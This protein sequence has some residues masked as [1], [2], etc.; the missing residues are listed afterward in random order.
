[1]DQP[2]QLPSDSQLLVSTRLGLPGTW[3]ELVRRHGEALTA[4][5]G[6]NRRRGSQRDVTRALGAFHSEI[7]GIGTPSEDGSESPP[8]TESDVRAVRPRMISLLT[9][10]T[11]GPGSKVNDAE[12]HAIAEAFAALPEPW[13]TALWHRAVELQPPAQFAPMLGRTATE[14]AA[15]VQRAEAG[16]FEAFLL[17]Q[18]SHDDIDD[19]CRPFIRLLGGA[20]RSS[21]S[22]HEQRVADEHLTPTTSR[23]DGAVACEACTRRVEVSRELL[24]LIPSAIVPALTGLSVDKYRAGVGTRPVIGAGRR[25]KFALAAGVGLLLVVLGAGAVLVRNV[26]E[27]LDASSITNETE[28]A[29][30]ANTELAKGNE[31]KL[32]T[33]TTAPDSTT[34]TEVELRPARTEPENRV[35]VVLPEIAAPV[36]FASNQSVLSIELSSPGPIFAGGTGTIDIVATNNTDVMIETSAL[37]EV[38]NGVFFADL[39]AGDAECVDPDDDWASCTFR[40]PAASS[41]TLTV[42][43]SLASSVVGS[44]VVGSNLAPDELEVPI[45]AVSRLLHSSIDH[46][47]I[48]MVG[49]TLMTCSEL[50]PACLDARD[51]VGDVL[52]RWDLPGAFIG[53]NPRL[54]WENSSAASFDIGNG[55]IEAAYLFW[56]GD[57]KERGVEIPDDGSNA[58][59][60][61][62][63]PGGVAGVKIEA[64]QI[65]RGDVDATQYFGVADVTD[66]IRS[67][68]PG[69]YLVGNVQ[70]VEVQGSYA[71]WSMVIITRDETLPRRSMTVTTPFSWFSP[72][73]VYAANIA[74]PAGTGKLAYLDVLAF[75]GDRSFVP[76]RLTIGGQVLGD[77]VFDSSIAGSRIPAD[78]N[79]FGMDI[80]AYNLKID[81]PEGNL[82]IKATSDEDGVRLA[83]LALAID[84]Q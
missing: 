11:Y 66:I 22:A 73:D 41:T 42:R 24:A 20:L 67:T 46:G 64:N 17:A 75:E 81:A 3:N 16:L 48:I 62:L 10:G 38:P 52:N 33:A 68:G 27:K 1:M 7:S 12:L 9:G 26:P 4:V 76:E 78:D 69:Q 56:S 31:T 5:A 65:R 84:V 30:D 25:S 53:S 55:S 40:I 58:S 18:R 74:V 83:V 6:S 37:L 13:Q 79:N 39:V 71:G 63:G 15:L 28:A 36:G 2:P 82:N 51:G 60:S 14:S 57:L 50:A 49:N 47:Q 45:S 72:D 32:T 61:L 21:L 70:S 19:D 44:F 34:T 8:S 59:V 23:D 77:E 43:F 29:T 80:D 54:G 35:S